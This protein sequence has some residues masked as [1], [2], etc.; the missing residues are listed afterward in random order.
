MMRNYKPS[1]RYSNR[2]MDPNLASPPPRELTL[3]EIRI[4]MGL[5]KKKPS[6]PVKM[7]TPV[8]EK[9]TILQGGR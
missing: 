8:L 1:E 5:E 3:D 9:P 6:E 7:F 2:S 4:R